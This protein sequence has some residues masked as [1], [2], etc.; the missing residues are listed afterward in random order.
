MNMQ[1]SPAAF[2]IEPARRAP[3]LMDLESEVCDVANYATVCL[4]YISTILVSLQ[5]SG[6]L[7][8]REAAA[9]GAMLHTVSDAAEQ[10]QKQYYEALEADFA[11]KKAT[12]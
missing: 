1:L 7:A 9:A 3:T 12:N 8:D 4:D 5:R 6:K 2:S 10:L 11:T